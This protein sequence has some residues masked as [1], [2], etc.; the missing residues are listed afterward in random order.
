M[1]FPPNNPMLYRRGKLRDDNNDN[2]SFDS[3]SKRVIKDRSKAPAHSMNNVIAYV[4][5]IVTYMLILYVKVSS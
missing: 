5:R 3:G 4:F 2:V 1:V